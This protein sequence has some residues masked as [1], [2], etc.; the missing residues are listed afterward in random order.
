MICHA[1]GLPWLPCWRGR[2]I[3]AFQPPVCA[4]IAAVA[5]YYCNLRPW[6]LGHVVQIR[7]KRDIM[8]V[9]GHFRGLFVACVGCDN[10]QLPLSLFPSLDSLGPA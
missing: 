9:A 10:V 3:P 2:Y 5:A 8:N 6:S 1:H 4:L 7:G